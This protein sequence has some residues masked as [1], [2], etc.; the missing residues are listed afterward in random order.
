VRAFYARPPTEE[1][2]AGTGFLPSDYQQA[3][4]EVWPENMRAISLFSALS[5]QLRTS[6]MGGVIGFDYNAYFA[7]MDRMNLTDQDYEWLFDDIRVI[8]SEAIIIL[9][10]KD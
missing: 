8:E 7:R 5:T 4:F 6:G 2:L 9:N 1:E 3:D 10:Q